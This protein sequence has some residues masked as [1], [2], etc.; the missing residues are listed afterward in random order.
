[1]SSFD[2]L[3]L[4]KLSL[5]ANKTQL[6]TIGQNISNVNTDG[7][8]R[9]R[10]IQESL[11]NRTGVVVDS[12]ERITDKFLTEQVWQNQSTYNQTKALSALAGSLDN[13]L[14]T[15]A[16]SVSS[17]MDK[18]FSA[19]QNVVD[20]PVSIPNR[21]LF[22]AQSKA[23]VERFNSLDSNIAK[24]NEQV[25]TQLNSYAAQVSTLASR[26]A[27]LNDKVRI[28]VAA[29]SP[30]SELL[31]QREQLTSE[32][33]KLIG[34]RVIDQGSEQVS[35]FIGN[36]QP[37]VVGG[38]AN[39]LVSVQGDPDAS[40]SQLKLRIANDLTTVTDEIVGGKLGGLL[41]YRSGV[42]DKARDELGLIALGFADSM[43]KQHA[44]GMDMNNELGERL[45]NDINSTQAQFNR[46]AANSNNQS[47]V[48][49]AQVSIED[50][51]KLKASDYELIYDGP[52]QITLIRNSDGK[53]FDID[54]LTPSTHDRTVTAG[55]AALWQGNGLSAS[56]LSESLRF[57]LNGAPAAAGTPDPVTSAKDAAQF[58]NGV[59]GISDVRATTS[60]TISGLTEAGL[61]SGGN[62]TFQLAV[63]DDGGIPRTLNV[64][65]PLAD[66]ATATG[67][68]I[69][70]AIQQAIN[71]D[72]ANSYNNISMSNSG[73][74]VT[75]TDSTGGNIGLTLTDTGDRADFT[76]LNS[77]GSAAAGPVT[78]THGGVDSNVATG[79]LSDG[80]A[81][82]NVNT[83]DITSTAGPGSSFVS[84]GSSS[85]ITPANN[86]AST[87]GDTVQGISDVSDGEFYLDPKGNSLSFSVDGFK[88]TIQA[89]TSLAEGDRFSLQPVRNGADE[90]DF[91]LRDGRKLALAS[92]IRITAATSNQGNGTAT[93]KV[94][95][96]NADAF[97]AEGKLTPPLEVRFNNTDP[98]TYTVYDVTDTNNP[99]VYDP[100]S[101]ALANQAYTAGAAIK[102]DGFEITIKNAP[103]SGDR[104]NFE[105]NKDGFSDN[106]NA[107]AVS[108]LQQAKLLDGGSYQDVYGSLVEDVGTR[109]ATARIAVDAN[110]SV[111]DSSVQAKSSVAGVNLDEEAAKLVQFQQAYQAS[112]QLI[113]VSKTLFDSLL[114]SI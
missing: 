44:L 87:L 59:D 38:S 52:N 54:S 73:A 103:K 24:Q 85:L 84:G 18:Y 53:R 86:V 14:A 94:T 90:M 16:T 77:N 112:A 5:Q 33:S 49:T 80:K 48:A 96:P 22:I 41:Q 34:I 110:K 2:L 61:S 82:K 42:L 17:A 83:L 102:V 55:T 15:K 6:S 20:D 114:S 70:L 79:Y 62:T 81:D 3:T 19:L 95:D 23:L 50:I 13:L 12:I 67:S 108:G 7:Y 4:G 32:L 74:G 28:S 26:I 98:L 8:T 56:G 69:Q 36:G 40:Q 60:A 97:G 101:G 76:S 66:S 99:R 39:E 47:Q 111:L 43:N 106:R 58:M 105:F 100:G 93:V 113:R 51:S 107:L 30:T 35:I 45:F 29:N 25:N 10:V 63:L 64:T 27:D 57:Q 89:R 1:M 78:L 109:T 9:Q 65:V 88:V 91:V 71:A 104:F 68:A 21:E 75:I 72:S 92:P 37:L 31:D 46:I 11:P